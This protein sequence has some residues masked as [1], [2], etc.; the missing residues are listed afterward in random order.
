MCGVAESVLGFDND[1]IIKR[2]LSAR[3]TRMEVAKGEQMI[4]ACII[5]VDVETKLAQSIERLSVRL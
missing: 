5:T 4:N 3:P 1:E 2:F